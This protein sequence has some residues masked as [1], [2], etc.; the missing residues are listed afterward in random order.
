MDKKLK[1]A[2]ENIAI[3]VSRLVVIMSQQNMAYCPYGDCKY[4]DIECYS[5][6]IC[7]KEYWNNVKKEMI[8]RYSVV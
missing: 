4:T 3:L 6:D 1:E 2:N 8:D 5:C 7:Q